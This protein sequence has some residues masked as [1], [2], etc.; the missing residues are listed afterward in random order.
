MGAREYG[1]I[2]NY[3]GIL[4]PFILPDV[5]ECLNPDL[6]SCP[7]NR[8]CVNTEGSYKCGCPSGYKMKKGKC[9]GEYLQQ[10]YKS[11]SSIYTHGQMP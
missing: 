7:E 6:Y 11:P 2:V 8:I 9:V 1:L 3:Y 5:N 4:H 10:Y